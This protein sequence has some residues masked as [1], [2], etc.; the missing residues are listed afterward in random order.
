MPIR[1]TAGVIAIAFASACQSASGPSGPPAISGVIVG[2]D[3]SISIGGPPTV[4]VKETVNEECGIIFTIRDP[5]LVQRRS[6][7][8]ALTPASISELTIGREVAV[9]A[10]G[11][12]AESCPA[13]AGA[14]AIQIIE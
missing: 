13:Q 6:P 9:W 5:V 3:Q 7:G 14:L 4:H 8:G 2:R 10:R 1:I 12:I 11:G